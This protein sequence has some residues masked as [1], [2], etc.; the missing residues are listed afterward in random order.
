MASTDLFGSWVDMAE[1]WWSRHGAPSLFDTRRQRLDSL[2]R[3]AR[4]HSPLYRDLYRGIATGAPLE[5]LPMVTKAR[6]MARFNDW[7][8]DPRIR[9]RDVRAFLADRTRIGAPFLDKYWV[10]KSSGT[11]GVP[12][13][14]VQDA[15][16]LNVYDALVMAQL[17]EVPWRLGS[18]PRRMSTPLRAALVVADGDHFASITSW[19]RMWRAP[20]VVEARSFSALEPLET[21]VRRLDAFAPGIL[22]GYPSLLAMLA[23]ERAAGRLAI[24]P[25]LIWSG[26]EHLGGSTRVAIENAFDCPVMNEYGASECMSIAH[27]CR[28]GWM[29][30][31][32][33]WVALEGV[34]ADG[35]PTP[36]G[37]L[38]HTCL[39][40]NLANWVQPV[41]R[42]DLGDR[43][44]TASGPCACGN[45]LPAFRLQGR[46]EVGLTLRS[47]RGRSVRLVPLALSTVVE[48]AAGDHRFQVAQT[49]PERLALRFAESG[50][51]MRRVR[52]RTAAALRAWLRLQKLPN[53]ELVAGSGAAAPRPRER[54][55]A[56]RGRGTSQAS[57]IRSGAGPASVVQLE[58]HLQVAPVIG[59][60]RFLE[61]GRAEPAHRVVG[62]TVTLLR[63]PESVD[64]ELAVH[65]LVVDD[66]ERVG[67]RRD[68]LEIAA[69]VA[70][71]DLD[72]HHVGRHAQEVDR[73]AVGRLEQRAGHGPGAVLDVE[74]RHMDAG[75]WRL[76][77]SAGRGQCQRDPGCADPAEN[78]GA[79]RLILATPPTGVLTAVK[80]SPRAPD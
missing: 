43:I 24:D 44:V 76:R 73:E 54:Q 9:L 25:L 72:H 57:L 8:T 68:V 49:G 20:T 78:L 42:Y 4:E 79:H 65:V 13:V 12:G 21:I 17:E 52:T 60:A 30:L 74:D 3:H 14:F 28:E 26:G 61:R 71:A 45:P 77:G 47:P 62:E 31:H 37:E 64:V 10:W 36:A 75:A 23:E 40:T 58:R 18:S 32:H 33:E 2:V 16:A 38:S 53:V 50:P 63:D 35:S 1:L 22:S 6:L 15:H 41:I 59:E 27:E 11:S 66:G 55:V 34:E 39:V 69:R 70:L 19:K 56:R 80:G 7:V 29:H 51:Q 46:S 5:Q 48:E 67:S